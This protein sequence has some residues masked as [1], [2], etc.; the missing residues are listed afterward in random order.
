MVYIIRYSEIGTK[1]K[2]RKDFEK[3]LVENLK[4]HFRNNE[5]NY[6]KV[7]RIYGRILVYCD[8]NKNYKINFKKI[9]GISSYSEAAET[10]AD[11]DDIKKTLIEFLKN[12]KFNSFRISANRIDKE[13]KLSSLEV[14]KE[15]GAFVVDNFHKKVS[16][17]DFDLELSV[18]FYGKRAFVFTEKIQC[19]AGL[20]V[21]SEGLVYSLIE[22]KNSILASVLMMKRGCSVIPLAFKKIDIQKLQEFMPLKRELRIIADFDELD[23]KFS[24]VIIS[25][26]TIDDFKNFN[27]ETDFL[28]LRPLIA[29]EDNEIQQLEERYA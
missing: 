29:F 19:F 14:E 11:L 21:G 28:I 1:G 25:G 9:F 27:R 10:N 6:E 16:L 4:H 13:F 7:E 26:Q 15:L 2:N 5:L 8:E 3:K 23:K 22:N 12:K 17:R 24:E 18:E 20:P